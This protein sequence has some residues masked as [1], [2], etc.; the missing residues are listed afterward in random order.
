MT[1]PQEADYQSQVVSPMGGYQ[2]AGASHPGPPGQHQ[3][4]SNTTSIATHDEGDPEYNSLSKYSS[5]HMR[6]AAA[7]KNANNTN[8]LGSGKQLTR[9]GSART[10]RATTNRFGG[11]PYL[12]SMYKEN[13]LLTASMAYHRFDKSQN[14][15]TNKAYAQTI[16]NDLKLRNM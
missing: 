9:R 14:F 12:A 6:A 7:M 8:L 4:L 11:N 2:G 3:L 10:K 13:D 1:M 15:N 5:N 16:I